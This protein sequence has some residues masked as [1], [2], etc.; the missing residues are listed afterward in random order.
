MPSAIIAINER[1]TKRLIIYYSIF[2][3]KESG[4]AQT[5]SLCL[6]SVCD[7][8]PFPPSGALSRRALYATECCHLPRELS[9][10]V[11]PIILSA[12]RRCYLPREPLLRAP[13]PDEPL[14]R[15]V[16]PDEPLLYDEPLLNDEPLLYEELLYDERPFEEELLLCCGV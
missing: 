13:P 11:L 9:C 12:P 7:L 8:L 14:L 2:W 15:E 4:L 6:I 5:L 16:L 3:H 10:V 1:V